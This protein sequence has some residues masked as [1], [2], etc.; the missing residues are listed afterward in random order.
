MSSLAPIVLFA[1]NRP[2][3]TYATLKSLKEN[4]LAERSELFIYCDGP[5]S[6]SD[7]STLNAIREVRE[8]VKSEKWC[9]VVTVIEREVNYGLSKSIITGVTA[10]VE[11]YGKIIVLED[12]IVTSKGFL[13]YMNESLDKYEK[14]EEVMHIASYFYP[15]NHNFKKQTFFLTLGTCWGW[16]TW[17][18]SW[19]SFESSADSLWERINEQPSN[20]LKEFDNQNNSLR[21]L[22]R[23][24]VGQVD[25]WAIRWYAS[26]FLNKGLGLHP[27]KSLVENIGFDGTGTNYFALKN[28]K[29]DKVNFINLEDIKI[30]KSKKVA[31]KLRKYFFRQRLISAP[32]FYFKKFRCLGSF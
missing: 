17:D 2:D 19:S 7:A 30:E 32:A 27:Y 4:D 5:K 18:S 22:R 8:I 14:V 24:K 3:H 10:I 9:K 31:L 20:I 12:D 6:T 29:V 21:L 26:I 1:Y 15:I 13:A 28:K 25:S 23:T 16:G 11:K